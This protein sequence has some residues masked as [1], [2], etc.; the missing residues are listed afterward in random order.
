MQISNPLKP[1][2]VYIYSTFQTGDSITR[3]DDF[4]FIFSVIFSL[5][6]FSV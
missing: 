1:T 2:Q 3:F 4:V 5:L 6:L